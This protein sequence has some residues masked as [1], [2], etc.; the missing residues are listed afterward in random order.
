VL[1]PNSEVAAMDNTVTAHIAPWYADQAA[2][3]ATLL[4]TLRQSV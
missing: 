1:E 4:L 2:A 3:G